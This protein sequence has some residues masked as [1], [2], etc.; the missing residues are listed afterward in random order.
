MR[1]MT[2]LTLA[3]DPHAGRSVPH[4]LT[5]TR[6]D[7]SCRQFKQCCAEANGLDTHIKLQY[8]Q[9]TELKDEFSCLIVSLISRNSRDVSHLISC[10]QSRFEADT[11][12]FFF[13]FHRVSCRPLCI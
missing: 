11:D 2:A 1:G 12:V 6:P 5:P 8:V 13:L 9:R 3:P 7:Y 4:G 10:N